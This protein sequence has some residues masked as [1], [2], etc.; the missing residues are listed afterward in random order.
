MEMMTRSEIQRITMTRSVIQRIRNG[1]DDTFRKVVASSDR[2]A[3]EK[4]KTLSYC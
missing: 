2:M 4:D 1:N 3:D